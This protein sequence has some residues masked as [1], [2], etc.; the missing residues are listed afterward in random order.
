MNIQ[1]PTSTIQKPEEQLTTNT[2]ITP[3]IQHDEL[4][5]KVDFTISEQVDTTNKQE[6]TPIESSPTE[7][8]VSYC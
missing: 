4:V 3:P 6:I 8:S 7:V 2:E 1:E 5:S